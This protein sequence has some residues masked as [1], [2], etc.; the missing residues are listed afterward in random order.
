MLSSPRSYLVA[1]ITCAVLCNCQSLMSQKRYKNTFGLGFSAA[2]NFQ[3][4]SI[5]AGIRASVP[6]GKSFSLVPQA[7][8]FFAFN[9]VH[10]LHGQ[11]NLHFHP[12]RLGRF[13]PYLIAG[14]SVNQWFSYA[15]SPFPQARALNFLAELGAGIS[16]RK[17]NVAFFAEHRYNPIWQEGTIH[18][19]AMFYTSKGKFGFRRKPNAC[20][21]YL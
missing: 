5:G 15:A 6:L 2:Y 13:T 12:I 7:T 9:P 4:E 16:V 17:R 11:V 14:A 10:E 3:T 8:Y 18:L 20:P 1:F 19:G 21:A